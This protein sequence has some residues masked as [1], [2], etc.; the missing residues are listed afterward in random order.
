MKK[1]AEKESILSIPVRSRQKA[2]K[3][4]QL[5]RQCK[6]PEK[7]QFWQTL[8][9]KCLSNKNSKLLS[10]NALDV[11]IEISSGVVVF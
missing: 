5:V 6:T 2:M 11:S 10:N 7:F 4:W 8:Y 3:P 1:K 9:R